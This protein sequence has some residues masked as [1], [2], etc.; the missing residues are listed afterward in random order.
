M[1]REDQIPD[2]R[3]SCRGSDSHDMSKLM[4]QTIR[5]SKALSEQY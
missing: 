5:G 4:K 1:H 2:A 3:K